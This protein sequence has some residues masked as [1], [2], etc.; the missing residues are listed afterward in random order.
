MSANEMESK[1]KELRE[2]RRMADEIAA[3]IE[4]LQDA[5]KSE[6]TARNTDTLTGTDWKVTWKAVTSKRFDSAA[7]KKTHGELYEQYT[8]ETTSKR[9]LIA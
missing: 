9:F 7:F 4:T 5:I 2:L 6:M 8:K 1:I 3:E